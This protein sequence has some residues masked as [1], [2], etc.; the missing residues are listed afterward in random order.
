MKKKAIVLGCGLVGA[1]MARDLASDVD[2]DVTVN[3]AVKRSVLR[4]NDALG[5]ADPIHR[6]FALG[7]V[8]SGFPETDS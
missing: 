7:K 6:G 8:L 4:S 3:R 1:T 5:G 2:F